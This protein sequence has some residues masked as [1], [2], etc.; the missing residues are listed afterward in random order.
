M[1]TFP[2][3]TARFLQRLDVKQTD[4]SVDYFEHGDKKTIAGDNDFYFSI[5][6]YTIDILT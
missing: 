3:T 2:S 5:L 6:L 1:H 4:D